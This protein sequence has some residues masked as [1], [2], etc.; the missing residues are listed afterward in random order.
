MNDKIINSKDKADIQ[1]KSVLGWLAAA[2]VSIAAL[3]TFA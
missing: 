2:A 1:F 3:A